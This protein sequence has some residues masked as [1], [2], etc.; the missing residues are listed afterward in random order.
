MTANYRLPT[1]VYPFLKVAGIVLGVYV[2][3]LGVIYADVV[4]R[5]RSS[6]LEGEKFLR[7]NNNPQDKIVFFEKERDRKLGKLEKKFQKGKIDKESYEEEKDFILAEFDW[8]TGESSIKNAYMWYKTAVDLFQPPRSKYVKLSEEKMK[9]AMAL[10]KSE[11]EMKGIPYE[12]WM[13]E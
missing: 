1:T 13:L 2:A 9:E 6:Y 7:W 10:W 4:L 3:M 8:H 11:L 5:A 12:E